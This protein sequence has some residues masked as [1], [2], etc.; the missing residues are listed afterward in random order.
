MFSSYIIQKFHTHNS[1]AFHSTT[2]KEE[3]TSHTTTDI[4]YTLTPSKFILQH[5]AIPERGFKNQ[6]SLLIII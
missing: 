5:D 1:V 6:A 3:T 2:E 4:V